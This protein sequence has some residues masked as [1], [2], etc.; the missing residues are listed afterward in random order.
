MS[1]KVGRSLLESNVGM[2]ILDNG[3]SMY[4]GVGI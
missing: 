4:S 3:H 1:P 2:V